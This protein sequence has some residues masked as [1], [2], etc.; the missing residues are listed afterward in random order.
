[1]QIYNRCLNLKLELVAWDPSFVYLH[2]EK[3]V[4]LGSSR[5]CVD[6]NKFEAT[7]LP[8]ILLLNVKFVKCKKI[9]YFLGQV[10]QHLILLKI[11]IMVAG[12]NTAALMHL[13]DFDHFSHLG[14]ITAGFDCKTTIFKEKFRNIPFMWISRETSVLITVMQ[15]LPYN[16]AVQT[17]YDGLIHGHW[18]IRKF[19]LH[20][21]YGSSWC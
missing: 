18:Y 9:N 13:S 20:Y 14:E 3:F 21:G 10:K 19:V 12:L 6:I 4:I 8:I 7:S 11:F 2:S 17:F 5:N 1:M 16:K 15:P